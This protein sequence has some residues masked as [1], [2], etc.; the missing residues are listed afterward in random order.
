MAKNNLKKQVATK[1]DIKR[2]DSKIKKIDLKIARL[3]KNLLAEIKAGDDALRAEM[4][5]MADTLRAEIKA[6][7]NALRAEMKEM[8]NELRTEFHSIGLNLQ[9]QINEIKEKMVTKEEFDAKFS[10]LFGLIDSVMGSITNYQRQDILRG[11]A[12]MRHEEKIND[13]EIRLQKLESK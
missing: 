4:K 2:L 9:Y 10:K 13:H 8:K 3:E 5:E 11:D 6:G 7:D 12:I 1:T